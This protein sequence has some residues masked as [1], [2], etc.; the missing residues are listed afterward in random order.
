MLPTGDILDR[1]R[2]FDRS[3]QGETERVKALLWAKLAA[4]EVGGWTE[5]CIDKLV[6]DF[7]NVKNPPSKAKILERLERLY[8]FQ[9]SREFRTIWVD[10]I[11]TILFDK[12]ESKLGVE[13]EKLESALNELKRSR[14]VSAHTYTKPDSRIDGPT[15]MIDLLQKIEAVLIKFNA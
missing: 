11:G 14:D 10:I 2:D 13:C 9:Y 3:C 8:G 4:I 12:I 1:L 15:R 5:E 6:K 7:V